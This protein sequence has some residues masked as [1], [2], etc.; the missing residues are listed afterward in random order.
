MSHRLV[1]IGKL[2]STHGIKGWLKLNIYNPQSSTLDAAGEI[3]LRNN[4][5]DSCHRLQQCNIHQTSSLIKLEG[6]DGIDAAKDLVGSTVLVPETAL[7]PA[8]PGEYYYYQALGLDMVDTRGVW[9]GKVT[10]IW[11]KEGG[12]LYVVS[13]DSGERLIPAV[14]DVI[15]KIDLAA[16]KIIIN[17][18]QGLLD[19]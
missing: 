16:K 7:A 3:I 13:G 10:R 12:D 15:E 14:R 5:G 8:G 11:I 4:H 6:I 17:P 1:P 9:I 19:L 18:P 2:V